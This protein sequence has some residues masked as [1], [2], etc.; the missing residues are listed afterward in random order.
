MRKATQ[1]RRPRRKPPS[2]R[3]KPRKPAAKPTEVVRIDVGR[4]L[5]LHL[6]GEMA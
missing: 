4:A 3:N 1:A 2:R 5:Y 6:L